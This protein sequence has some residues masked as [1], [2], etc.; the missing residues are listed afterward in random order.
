MGVYD[1]DPANVVFKSRL[2]PGRMLLVD[3]VEKSMIQDV[4]LKLHISQS[5][6]HR[7]WLQEQVILFTVHVN[8]VLFRQVGQQGN[9]NN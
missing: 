9:C 8:F 4:E 3:T 1:V 6:P 5:R 7:Q 2:K